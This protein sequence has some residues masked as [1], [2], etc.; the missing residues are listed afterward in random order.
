MIHGLKEIWDLRECFF[1][2]PD[3]DS[4]KRK[5]ND[6]KG[7]YIEMENN[8]TIFETRHK[9]KVGYQLIVLNIDK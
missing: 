9:S 6:I 1:L 4:I 7:C 2:R 3:Q 5:S 8:I